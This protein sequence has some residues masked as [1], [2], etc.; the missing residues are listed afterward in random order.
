M[1]SSLFFF[2]QSINKK[3]YTIEKKV[4]MMKNKKRIFTYSAVGCCLLAAVFFTFGQDGTSGQ[5]GKLSKVHG[6]L[7]GPKSCTKCHSSA[8][9]IAPA[10]CLS[11]HKEL[12]RRI[13]EG[14]GF[15]A[16][17]QEECADCHAEHNG[18][19]PRLAQWDRG[20]FDHSETGYTLTGAHQ[21]IKTC[22]RC[23][24][25]GNSPPRK[26][27]QTFLLNNNRCS[28]C[29]KDAHRGNQPICTDCHGTK[30]WSVDIW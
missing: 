26:Y 30:D 17:K 1:I 4:K 22:E 7:E 12:S 9:K 15:H 16:D 27:S 5:P 14:R 3:W 20:S 6:E 28:A 2:L 8:K 23:H 11:C 29:H 13:K 19:N 24:H 18:E 25:A 21:K 10:K